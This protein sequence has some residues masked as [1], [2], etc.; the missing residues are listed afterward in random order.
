MPEIKKINNGEGIRLDIDLE[1]IE[2][3]E[4]KEF[5]YKQTDLTFKAPTIDSTHIKSNV[6]LRSNQTIILG[7][8]N[9]NLAGKEE[10]NK[11]LL[12]LI[13]AKIVE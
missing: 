8:A 4:W 12:V 1:K 13:K 10:L 3:P 6:F 9:I 7:G 11:K 2:I 5:T